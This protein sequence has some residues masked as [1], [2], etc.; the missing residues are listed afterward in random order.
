MGRVRHRPPHPPPQQADKRLLLAWSS[1]KLQPQTMG[2][3][4]LSLPEVGEEGRRKL[5]R[6]LA[7]G[8]PAHSRNRNGR[9]KGCQHRR[10]PQRPQSSTCASC[11]HLLFYAGSRGAFVLPTVMIT[12]I[13]VFGPG[14]GSRTWDHFLITMHLSH[15]GFPISPARKPRI[16]GVSAQVRTRSDRART[17]PQVWGL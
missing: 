16:H 5:G 8:L 14:P 1:G 9:T 10:Q 15:L 2:P 6:S 7:P 12:P 3:G 11:R 13:T 4:C 17:Q